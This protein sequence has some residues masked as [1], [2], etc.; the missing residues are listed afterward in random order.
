LAVA[1]D[2]SGSNLSAGLTADFLAQAMKQHIRAIRITGM[3]L[4]LSIE[5]YYSMGNS[6]IIGAEKMMGAFENP[7]IPGVTCIVG[8]PKPLTPRIHTLLL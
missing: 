6:K 7:R 4:P 2:F 8:D 5:P 3:Y 1:K